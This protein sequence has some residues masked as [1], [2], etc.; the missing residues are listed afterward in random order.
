MPDLVPTTWNPADK[1]P[2]V[3]LSDGDLTA[4]FG[5]DYGVRSVFGGTTGKFYWEIEPSGFSSV[6]VATSASDLG[7]IPGS[8][9]FAWALNNSGSVLN[10]GASVATVPGYTPPAVLSVLLDMDGLELKFWADGVEIVSVP[11]TGTEFFAIAGVAGAVTAN[12]GATPFAYSPPSGY[13]EG[14]GSD[15]DQFLPVPGVKV[16]TAGSPSVI[17]GPNQ[18]VGV[19]GLAALSSGSP[20]VQLGYP[21]TLLPGGTAV[22]SAGAPT[23]LP[24]S[25][26]SVQVAGKPLFQA[27]YPTV[28]YDPIVGG[29]EFIV[30]SGVRVFSAGTPAIGAAATVAV[31]GTAL[32][33]PGTP[34]AKVS[35]GVSGPSLLS[36]GTPTIGVG[37]KAAGVSLVR[38]GTPTLAATVF[39]AGKASLRAGTPSLIA[40][41]FM[42]QPG[43]AAVFSAGLPRISNTTIHP[44]GKTHFRAGTPKAVRG[45][46][47]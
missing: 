5:G 18:V 12:F 35:I 9:A 44:W 37:V 17:R 34:A 24:Y 29:T 2:G 45:S 13:F 21:A 10:N 27:G 38:A 15:P 25:N 36:A 46:T 30:P 47:C 41:D 23:V 39:P 3:V 33:S 7:S 43:G 16:F 19:T 42:L 1:D 22:F 28:E 40:G 31:P 32:F 8:D 11:L 4:S 26:R 14:L 20:N 6:G